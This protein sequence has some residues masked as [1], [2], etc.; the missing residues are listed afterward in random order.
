MSATIELLHSEEVLPR[1]VSPVMV[2]MVEDGRST[3]E[4]FVVRRPVQFDRVVTA[5]VEE[6][7]PGVSAHR[8]R[9]WTARGLARAVHFG[10]NSVYAGVVEPLRPTGFVI[11]TRTVEPNNI[12]HLL[13][14]VIPCVLHARRVVQAPVSVITRSLQGPFRCLLEAFDI[15]I[16]ETRRQVQGRFLKV[17][18]TRGL[19]VY[20]LMGHPHCPANVT[21]TEPFRDVDFRAGARFDRVFLARRGLRALANHA[22]VEALLTPLGYQTIFMEDYSIHDQLSIGMQARHVVAIHGAAMAFL[23]LNQQLESVV[24]LSPSHVYHEMFPLCV[25]KPARQYHFVISEFDRKVSHSGWQAILHH[26][27]QA[28]ASD[29]GLLREALAN[30]H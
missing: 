21:L 11:D 16:V 5:S 3:T 24:E 10:V 1:D 23:A 22:A 2:H 7:V 19:S 12:A 4:C 18:G 13:L 26:K 8:R 20:D 9:D 6:T 27:G 30:I 14:E 15:P 29:V 25:G 28:F 17:R